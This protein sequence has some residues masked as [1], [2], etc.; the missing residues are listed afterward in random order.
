MKIVYCLQS[1]KGV[2]GIERVTTTKANYWASLG[3]EVHLITTDQRQQPLAYA[4]DERV[5][6]HDI[7]MNYELDNS[8]GRWGRIRALYA[9]R[10]LHRER[11][12]DLLMSIRADV[13]V[14]TF[15]Q[16]APILPKI[17]DGSKKVL[18]LHSSKYRRV[19]QYRKDQWLMRLVGRAR[20]FGDEQLS[21]SYDR[22]VILN[23][24]EKNLW[25]SRTQVEV[26]PNPRPFELERL[27][28]LDSKQ[29][30]AIG[31]YQYEKNF[32]ELLDIWALV[33]P[34]FPDWTLSIVG[35]GS[36]RPRLEEKVIALGLEAS[37]RLTP[38]T[39]EV[40]PY[41]QQSSI[42]AMTSHYEGLPMVLIEAQSMG[43][44]IISYNCQ[45]GPRYMVADGGDGYLVK[46]GDK[47]AFASKLRLLMADSSLR[48]RLGAS[49]RS[50]A[51]QRYALESVMKQW[52][53]LLGSLL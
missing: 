1:L 34:D 40:E 51:S 4:L 7:E 31:R 11:L 26:I 2:G 35:D 6:H 33:S 10:R 3:Y 32:E 14:S 15:F 45:S 38:S 23:K 49:A 42:Y 5:K 22:L 30:I 44:P 9:K 16:E 36:Y 18:E 37:V 50:S 27:A 48:K 41:Y 29:V 19:F 17:N 46:Q 25:P 53:E 28:D 47:E 13:V 43:L 20:T 12:T 52:K 8:L 39:S 21:K 24:G